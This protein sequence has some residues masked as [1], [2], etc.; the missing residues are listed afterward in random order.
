MLDGI[1]AAIRTVC[2]N[3]IHVHGTIPVD[4]GGG[5]IV[6]ATD[7]ASGRTSGFTAEPPSTDGAAALRE[8]WRSTGALGDFFDGTL[9]AL[10]PPPTSA[11]PG[12]G[13]PHVF[14]ALIA[15]IGAVAVAA[16]LAGRE[17]I[18]SGAR[19]AHSRPAIPSPTPSAES[20]PRTRT[21]MGGLAAH[22]AG[23]SVNIDGAPD[24]RA[25]AGSHPVT[26]DSNELRELVPPNPPGTRTPAPLRPVSPVPAVAAGELSAEQ[27]VTAAVDAYVAAV[28]SQD[29]RRLRGVYPGITPAEV[30][31][32]QS[33]FG[34][35]RGAD[36]VRVSYHIERDPAID[37]DAATLI[38]TLTLRYTDVAG[39][40]RVIP[41]P[42]RALLRRAGSGWRLDEVLALY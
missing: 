32:W 27:R 36:D 21:P 10:E 34:R 7:P 5:E 19:V 22:P 18:F 37:D 31:R 24:P 38:F 9:Y 1:T 41:M 35:M 13:K 23:S 16:L 12:F 17:E 25:P 3:G 26:H 30:A 14:L 6:L 29:V 2:G 42:L 8:V 4:G 11:S 33:Q 20:T 39:E 28:R 40:P 15:V